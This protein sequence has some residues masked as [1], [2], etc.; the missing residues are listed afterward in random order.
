MAG[1]GTWNAAGV[2]VFSPS[3][4]GGLYRIS[5]SG[6]DLQVLLPLNAAKEH[7]SY[8]W[9]HFLPDG[10]RF[11]FLALGAADKTNEFTR[12]I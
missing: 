6:A 3:L 8:R 11:T 7:R 2:I 5:E 4:S 10:R 12:A 9:P 1:G